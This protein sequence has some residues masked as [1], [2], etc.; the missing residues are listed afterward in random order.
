MNKE[1]LEQLLALLKQL[2]VTNPMTATSSFAHQG[3]ALHVENQIPWMLDSDA[4]DHMTGAGIGEDNWN[5]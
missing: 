5:C 2:T 1:Q 3:T 4:S